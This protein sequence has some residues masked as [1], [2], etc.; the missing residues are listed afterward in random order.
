MWLFSVAPDNP[1]DNGVMEMHGTNGVYSAVKSVMHV[2]RTEDEEARPDMAHRMIQIA[3]PWK[4][5]SWSQLKLA[6][7]KA[8]VRILKHNVHLVDAEWT[9]EEQGKLN[10]PVERYTLRSASRAWKVY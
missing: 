5:S 3:M 2:I 8:L 7:G 6:N 10:I 9:E 1:E 4:I